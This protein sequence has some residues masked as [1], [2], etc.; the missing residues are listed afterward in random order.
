MA[1]MAVAGHAHL[2]LMVLLTAV[3]AA[4]RLHVRGPQLA[5]PIALVLATTAIG[6]A[7]LA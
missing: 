1:A 2:A 5:R 4:Q 3:V 6:A 7:A